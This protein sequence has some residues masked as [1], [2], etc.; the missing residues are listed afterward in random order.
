[1][2]KTPKVSLAKSQNH[3]GVLSALSLLKNDLKKKLSD[4]PS[5]VVK[6]NFVDTRTELATTPFQ[7][8]KNFVDFV[9]P[10]FKGEIVIAEAPSW[11]VKV[12]PF[13]KYGF[14]QLI[15][16]Y[17]QVKLVNLKEG[18]YIEKKIKYPQGEVVLSFSKAIIE[19][20]FLV[21]ITRPKTHNC[22]IATLGLK[23]VIF[24]AMPSYNARL[25]A[26]KG[27]FIHHVMAE[28]ADYAYPDLIVIDGTI[29]MEGDGPI[30]GSAVKSGWAVASL[31][32]LAADSLGVY[33]MGFEIEDIGYLNLLKD[34]NLGA[35]YPKDRIDVLGE[36]PEKLRKPFKPHKNFEKNRRWQ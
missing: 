9:S 5:I 36:K 2:S 34:K 10:F 12:D 21:S 32:A 17:S 16:E 19:A 8:V 31:D 30:K 20:P 29:G 23:N 33:L 25:K 22:V 24:G 14:N 7:A 15:K 11:G 18:K 28:I 6:V 4:I 27:K 13:E 35:L 1:M 3:E 26:H